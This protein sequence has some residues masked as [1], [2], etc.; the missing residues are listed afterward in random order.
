[1]F[2]FPLAT[3]AADGVWSNVGGGSWSGSSNWS[4]G[5]PAGGNSALA[6]FSQLDLLSAT[7]VTLNGTRTAGFLKF[8]DVSPSHDWS[9]RRGSSGSLT[10]E[11]STGTPNIE[12]MNRTATLG[13]DLLGGTGLAKSGAGTLVLS[14]NNTYAGPTLIQAGT[15]KLAPPPVF[16][17]GMKVM[18][19][20][21]SITNGYNGAN[22]G[23]RGPLYGMLL[24]LAPTFQYV[25]TSTERPGFLPVNQQHHEGHSSYAVQ[26][27]SNNLDGLDTTI[28][29]LYGGPDRDP[30]GGFWITGGGGTGR[31][32]TIP[33][34][35]TLMA[36]TNDL[37]E[38]VGFQERLT[39]L[40]TKLNTLCPDAKILLARITPITNSEPVDVPAL[41]TMIDQVTNDF[42]AAGKPVFPVDLNT[43]FPTDGMFTDGTHP[44]DTGFSWM[45]MQ[46][47]EGILKACTPASGISGG[48]PATTAV[49]VAS[50]A[51]LDF[52]GNQSSITSLNA[53]GTVSLGSGGNLTT[54]AGMVLK[55]SG[56]L[57]GSGTI[58]GPVILNGTGFAHAG[59][60]LVFTDAVTLNGSLLPGAGA[61][62]VFTGNFV[63]N[64][65]VQIPSGVTV[66]FGGDVINNGVI[67]CTDGA[68]LLVSGTF[69]NN[70][71]LD[72]LTGSQAL[73]AGIIDNGWIIGE[74][75]VAVH[76]TAIENGA[77]RVS[78][79]SYS[80]HVYQL[81]RSSTL[82]AG[83][84]TNVG[85]GRNGVTGVRLDFE[86]PLDSPSGRDFFRIRV[87][88]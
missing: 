6:D 42:R 77:I 30:N 86:H 71:T 36:G 80:G 35:I 85:E 53:G 37:D 49:T 34:V 78:I 4:A 62:L 33:D 61:N 24:P 74:D 76:S 55:A 44:N 38:P 22:A 64:G 17:S 87:S 29:Q 15:L 51:T 7:T 43:T 69:E 27:L 58:Q 10:L 73:P 88:P 63:N 84:W 23:Y 47:Y 81:Q 65:V 41:N 67:R 68:S 9:I 31:G 45:A 19:L 82:D 2:L 18:P 56:T 72:I 1:L 20:G 25:G 57:L 52:A 32:P 75:K 13:V 8:G 70:G 39:G 66:S 5:T 26:D 3:R 60:T 14:G 21:D 79:D 54:S 59:Q 28:Y 12:V 16:P 11:A 50:G 48:L 83:S 46:W 40:I